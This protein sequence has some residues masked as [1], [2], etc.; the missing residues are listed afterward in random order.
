MVELVNKIALKELNLD[1]LTDLLLS[2]G[3]KPF[4]AK[5]I[6]QWMFGNLV[7]DFDEMVNLPKQLRDKLARYTVLNLVTIKTVQ[8]SS[9]ENTK[10]YLFKLNDGQLIEGVLMDYRYGNTACLSTQVGCRMGCSFCAST[11]GGLIRNL[12]AGEILDQLISMA[13]DL[14]AKGE[15]ISRVV[16]MGTGEPLDNWKEV[17]RFLEYVHQPDCFNLGY[18]KITIST[19]GLVPEII[20]LAEEQI[21][22]NLAISL[23]APNDQL[24]NKL[25]PINYKYSIQELLAACRYYINKTNRRITFEYT[26]IEGINDS[27]DCAVQLAHILSDLLCHVNLIPLNPIKEKDFD[28]SKLRIVNDFKEIL[29]EKGIRVTVRRKLGLDI[30][31]ACG[32]LRRKYEK[33]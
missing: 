23:H 31:A 4:R 13:R 32:Q 28:R 5:Q 6:R 21:P 12:K 15:K 22:I 9:R 14:K 10:K 24:R 8:H 20:S 27:K 29:E 11:L 33:D 18:R 25:M 30:D 1:Q 3:E 19:C 16:L 7:Q 26:L 17:R 2:W